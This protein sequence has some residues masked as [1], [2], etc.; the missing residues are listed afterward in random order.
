MFHIKCS[1]RKYGTYLYSPNPK[2]LPDMKK[3]ER[4]SKGSLPAAKSK[5]KQI[6][7]IRIVLEP[8]YIL[9]RR[10]QLPTFCHIEVYRM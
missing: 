4:V 6:D 8:Y 1:F 9:E 3:I 7:L 10:R 2:K 5:N